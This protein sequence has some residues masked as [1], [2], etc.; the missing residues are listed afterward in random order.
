[1]TDEVWTQGRLEVI[2]ELFADDYRG[3]DA[4]NGEIV[5]P[6]GVRQLVEL[7]RGAFSNVTM[8][9]DRVVAEGDWVVSTWTARGTHTG[10]LV[11]VAPTGREATVTGV[12]VSRVSGGKFVE[13]QGLFDALGMLQQIGAV[14]TA[15]A[16][17]APA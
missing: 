3:W 9:S 14:P 15:A 4:T 1:M 6:A 11:G 2:D 12:E 5:G 13:S 7:Y 8:T 16:E 17:E 10:E